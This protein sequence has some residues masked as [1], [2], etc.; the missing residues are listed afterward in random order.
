MK[1]ERDR[2]APLMSE[3]FDSDRASVRIGSLTS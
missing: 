2:R 1:R 3:D